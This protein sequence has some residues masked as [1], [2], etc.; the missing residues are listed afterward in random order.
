METNTSNHNTKLKTNDL[1]AIVA[2]IVSVVSLVSTIIITVLINNKTNTLTEKLNSKEFQMSESVKYDLIEIAAVLRSI[3]LKIELRKPKDPNI[4]KYKSNNDSKLFISTAT[5]RINIWE[6][7]DSYYNDSILKKDI[8]FSNEIAALS[9]IQARPSYLFFLHSIDSRK[10]RFEIEIGLRKLTDFYLV[11]NSVSLEAIQTQVFLIQN[12]LA[13]NVGLKD[14]ISMDFDGLMKELCS[15]DTYYSK[16]EWSYD[17]FFELSWYLKQEYFCDFLKML[18]DKGNNDPDINHYYY[19]FCNTNRELARKAIELGAHD[20][21]TLYDEQFFRYAK[22]LSILLN[23]TKDAEKKSDDVID[24][25]QFFFSTP[26][27]MEEYRQ[28][29]AKNI[30]EKYKNEYQAFYRSK[31]AGDGL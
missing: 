22:M 29:L 18:I 19:T 14:E 2:I 1:L 12:V 24:R 20:V 13:K 11:S 31:V 25:E 27:V 6:Y 10:H 26:R 17:L 3:D 30:V 15:S 7:L 4:L 28:K 23:S 9:E 5:D 8:D 16:S 21:D